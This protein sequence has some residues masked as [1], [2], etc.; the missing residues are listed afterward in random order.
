MYCTKSVERSSVRTKTIFGRLVPLER[1]WAGALSLV[2]AGGGASC[3]TTV[4]RDP[5][6]GLAKDGGASCAVA[7]GGALCAVAAGGGTVCG[8]GPGYGG[9]SPPF[10]AGTSR[11]ATRGTLRMPRAH[12]DCPKAG[13]LVLQA[14]TT[15]GL[16]HGNGRLAPRGAVPCIIGSIQSFLRPIPA[17]APPGTK[18]AYRQADLICRQ[19]PKSGAAF[20]ANV[21]SPIA[22]THIV[23]VKSHLWRMLIVPMNLGSDKAEGLSNPGLIFRR[24]FQHVCRSDPGDGVAQ[25][26][27][28]GEPWLIAKSLENS[29]TRS[30]S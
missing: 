6:C 18:P 25:P 10:S 1:G 17:L 7:A 22:S 14:A 9:P 27:R 8:G 29:A 23:P 26:T 5:S 4:G 11:W 21:T 28:I 16:I 12:V 30:S 24:R 19:I 13:S 20:K 2:A 15:R 3:A